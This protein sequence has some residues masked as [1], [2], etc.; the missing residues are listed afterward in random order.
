ME[1]LSKD[2]IFERYVCL[3]R[4]ECVSRTN[5]SQK[6]QPLSKETALYERESRTENVCFRKQRVCVS[7]R[8]SLERSCGSKLPF[9]RASTEKTQKTP[10]LAGPLSTSNF[11]P[12]EFSQDGAFK[13]VY[14]CV[15]EH[16]EMEA[17]SVADLALLGDDAS[18][19]PWASQRTFFN[20]PFS[21]DL[22]S[23]DLFSTDLFS[24]ELFNGLAG[25]EGSGAGARDHVFA[26]APRAA[27]RPPA[28][29]RTWLRFSL[30]LSRLFFKGRGRWGFTR[31]LCG[32]AAL[33]KRHVWIHRGGSFPFDSVATHSIDYGYS[34]FSRLRVS[35]NS[36]FQFDARF[37]VGTLRYAFQI[38]G[39]K[40]SEGTGG[41]ALRHGP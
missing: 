33:F 18:V 6:A 34:L 3:L 25:G 30:T 13:R 4:R 10:Y 36:F 1:C 26:L 17:V 14:R 41:P 12:F 11:S 28:S 40:V 37:V 31:I 38:L 16:G 19:S 39:K 35:L 8:E 9:A 23:T 22:F 32:F 24:T 27:R 29:C 7:S 5:H 2:S 15:N 21:T 20:G